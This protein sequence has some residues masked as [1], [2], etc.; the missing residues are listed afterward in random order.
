MGT[1]L[2]ETAYGQDVIA[3]KR[4]SAAAM[5]PAVA[6]DQSQAKRR[7]L[8]QQQQYNGVGDATKGA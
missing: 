8:E 2:Q 3:H 6:S 1:D 4:N 5:Q 7:R